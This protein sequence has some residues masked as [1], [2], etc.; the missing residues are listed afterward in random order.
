[1]T[2]PVLYAGTVEPGGSWPAQGAIAPPERPT[3]VAAFNSGFHTSSSGGGWFDHGR[4]AVA[5]R[6]GAASLIIRADGSATVGMWGRDDRLTPDIV[7]VRQ[8]LGLLVDGSAN[9]AGS[10][11]WG[12]TLRGV[13]Y[14]W[15]SALG[16]DDTGDLIYAGGPGLDA[17]SLAQVMIQAG[18][19][20]AME[21]DINPQWVSFSYYYSES[22]AG[23]TLLAGMNFGP[24]HW[25]T[26][27]QR[28]FITI[29][30][31]PAL[32]R[33]SHLTG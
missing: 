21:L 9:M 3:L 11:S 13:R 2:R 23:S 10:G 4:T 33:S 31:R 29:F 26:G 5:L 28:D 25:L 6:E 30:T 17:P 8:N 24:N 20:R 7:S 14:T 27:S 22:G 1:V 32:Q 15:R 12:A 16:V 18:A 19:I